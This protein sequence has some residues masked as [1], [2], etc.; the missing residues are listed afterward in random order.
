MLTFLV[1]LYAQ[2]STYFGEDVDVIAQRLLNEQ[3]VRQGEDPVA[4]VDRALPGMAD[5]QAVVALTR[6]VALAGD[7]HTSVVPPSVTAA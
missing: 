4:A 3:L 1:A 2:R 5:H 7:A 6:L